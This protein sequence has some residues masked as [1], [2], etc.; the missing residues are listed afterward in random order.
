MVCSD[1]ETII[2]FFLDVFNRSL[3]GGF[4]DCGEYLKVWIALCDYHRRAIKDWT[5]GKYY[6]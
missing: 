2:Y 4:G 5:I 6:V 1:L 3:K